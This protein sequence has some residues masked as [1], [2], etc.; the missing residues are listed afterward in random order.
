MWYTASR[1]VCGESA[2]RERRYGARFRLGC[3]ERRGFRGV[4]RR[5]F[6]CV[7]EQADAISAFTASGVFRR[8]FMKVV[9]PG[10]GVRGP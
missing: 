5:M 4:R 7:L 1:D 2:S 8:A 10:G 3:W 6:L 9:V